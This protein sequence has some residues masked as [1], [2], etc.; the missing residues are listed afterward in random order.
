M[1]TFRHRRWRR[2]IGSVSRWLPAFARVSTVL[3]LIA[4]GLFVA[5]RVAA[6][7]LIT[8]GFVR[9]GIE[10]ALSKWTGYHAEIKGSPVLEFWPT[11]RITINQITIRQPRESGDKLL[12][13]IESLSAD[14]SLIDALRGRTSFHEFHLLRPNLAL[15]RDEKGLIDWSYAGLLARAISGVRYEN[16]AE[17]LDRDLDAE[18]G[19]VTVEDGTLVV[20]DIRSARTYH[21][22]SVTA[23][24]AWPRLSGAISA[25]VIARINGVDLKVDFASRQP[26]LAFAGKSAETRTSL[27]SNLLTARFQGVASIASL[28]ALSGNIAV[29]IPD[30]PALLTWSGRSIPGVG[31][32]KSASL[33]SDIMSSGSGLRF[34]DLSLSL[35]DA[36]ATGVMDLSTQPGRRPKIG[37]TLAFDQMNLKPFLD[38]FALRLA[39]GEA[40]E[41]SA[42]TA[43]PLQLLDVDVRLSARRAQMGLFELSDVGASMIVSGGEA[44]FDIGDSQ[45]E[46]GEMTAHLEATRRDFDGGGKLQLS[47]RDADFAGLA[48]R[49]QL[50]GPLP[51]ATG[52]LDL[53]LRSPKAI[54]T[55]GL[56]DVTG[57]LRF[58]TREGTIPGIDVAALRTEA[59]EKPFFPLSAAASGAFTF[60]RL[61][62]QADF[63]N[64]SA[65]IH[66]ALIVG[67]AQTL[68]LSGMITYQSNGLALSG[69]LEAT[70]PAKAAELPLLPFFIGGSWPNPVVSPVPHFGAMPHAR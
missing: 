31:T 57:R 35:N 34:N 40:E 5:L 28:S 15:T 61:D 68:A 14:F 18:I 10:D 49:L 56:A 27:T 41:I 16:G 3:L 2:K 12:G 30:V 1:G 32:L 37:G 7:Y 44:K 63:A 29:S 6:P 38:A 8:T 42:A 59:A 39:A 55:T 69:S 62:L 53:D 51:L 66:D 23:D 52:S 43:E 60:N 54:W 46:G 26:L 48:E 17:V 11:P 67:P 70:D 9:S 13:R 47:I 65:E 19:A 22:D 64:G 45:F 50:K 58:W 24:I 36:S 25:V 33:D 4:L 21:F 20:T